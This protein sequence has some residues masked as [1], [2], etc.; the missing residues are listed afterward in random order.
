MGLFSSG[1]TAF[2]HTT[3]VIAEALLLLAIMGALVLGS[4]LLWKSAPAGADAV[5]A[6][7]G[8][9]GAGGASLWIETASLRDADGLHFGADV[10]FG[11]RSEL[12]QS[13]QL[14]CFIDGGLVFGDAR[15][16]FEGGAGYGEPFTLG[17]SLSWTEGA[18]DCTATLGHRARNGR[19]VTE[20]TLGFAV[21]G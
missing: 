15:M 5:Q 10:M 3:K 16:L 21:A 13:I 1:V 14:Q 20:A 19:F 8:G 7:K 4:A 2:R 17:G 9:S 18:A 12:A 6:A 11:Y